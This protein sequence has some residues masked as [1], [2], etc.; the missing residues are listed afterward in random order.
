M[1]IIDIIFLI[2]S[3]IFIGIGI[4]R[5]FT[6]EIF[7]IIAMVGG[8]IVAFLYYPD[9][10]KYFISLKTPTELKNG[11]SFFIIYV[12]VALLLLFIG[13]LVKKAIHL[14]VLGWIDRLLGAVVGLLKSSILAYV[15]CLS[16]ASIPVKQTNSML[17]KSYTFRMYKILPDSLHLK[18]IIKTRDYVKNFF[19]SKTPE[20]LDNS[21]KELDSIKDNVEQLP[22]SNFKE[23]R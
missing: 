19:D 3:L 7:R 14:T 9:L 1:Q 15:V 6:G 18:S 16:V 8:F 21:K 5:G 13:W 12:V 11:L 2:I 23:K 20:S 4:K 10:T 17:S 22:E